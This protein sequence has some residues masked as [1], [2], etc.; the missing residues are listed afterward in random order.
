MKFKVGDK[1][2]MKPNDFLGH[3][4]VRC[5]GEYLVRKLNGSEGWYQENE[6]ELE[7]D[8]EQIS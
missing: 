8:N 4:L 7:A 3:I 1:V 2:K 6:L 5:N